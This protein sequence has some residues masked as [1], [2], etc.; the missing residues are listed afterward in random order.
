MDQENLNFIGAATAG[1]VTLAWL[2]RSFW[3]R[4][5]RD[6][7]EVA[8]DRAEIDI[9]KTLQHQVDVLIKENRDLRSNEADLERRLGQ[10][11]SKEVEVQDARNLIKD[12]RTKLEEKDDRIER[13]IRDH[14]NETSSLRQM[15]S[16]RDH[17]VDLLRRRISELESR[18]KIDEAILDR[19]LTPRPET[20]TP[21]V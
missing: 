14:T 1:S 9:L 19:R 4:L 11:E 12:L 15:L 21:E 2:I 3:R 16:T 18:L 5:A 20:T 10:L 13:L 8:K 6:S 7:A 17:E